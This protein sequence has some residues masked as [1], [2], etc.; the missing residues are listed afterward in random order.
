MKNISVIILSMFVVIFLTRL[1]VLQRAEKAA[2]DKHEALVAET[3]ECLDLGEWKCAEKGIKALLEESPNDTNLQKHLAIILYEQ[4]RYE[5]CRNYIAGLKFNDEDLKYL[6]QKV[7]ALIREMAELGIE[8]SMH[9]RVEFEGSPKKSD[10]MEALAVLEVAYDSLS[11]LFDFRP[12]NKLHLVLYQ[13]QEYQ[14][15]GPRPDWVG[16]VFDGKL[17]VPVN[18][19][20]Y[21][22]IY[23]P[24]LF[25]ELTHAFVRGMTRATVPLWMN[26]GIAQVVDA[27]RTGLP[28]PEGEVPS[29]KSLTEPFVNESNTE[30]AKKLYWYSQRMVE[31]LLRKDGGTAAFPK[32]RACI[33]DLRVL[34][35]DEALKKHYGMNAEQLLEA[36][37]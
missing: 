17:R 14:G 29:L 36:V 24:M 37:K 1:V 5:E 27:S 6:D 16:A 23:R 33:Q 21:R 10:V 22:E 8:R 11:R 30:V 2:F 20:Q 26:E 3:S 18:V 12:E 34:G 25:H 32:F 4:E 28:R 31:E 9:F 7:A 19:M 13:S 15:V 35:I